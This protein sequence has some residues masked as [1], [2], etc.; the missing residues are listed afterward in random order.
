MPDGAEHLRRLGVALPP[1]RPFRGIRYFDGA[2]RIDGRFPGAPGLGL[3]R[4]RLHAALVEAAE[5]ADV[6][7]RWGVRAEGLQNAGTA[8]PTVLTSHGPMAARL[9][10]GADGLHSK[11]RTWAGLAKPFR[12]RRR[13]GVRRHYGLAPWSDRVEVY[14]SD[15]AE[16]YVTPVGDDEIGV[17]ILWSGRKAGFDALL[18]GFPDLEDKLRGAAHRSRDRGAGPLRQRVRS[19][20]ANRVA[21]VGDAAGYVDAITGEGLSVALHQ[22]AALLDA[23]TEDALP[24]YPRRARRV[25]FLPEAL[26][27]LLLAI[28]AR[29]ALRRRVMRALARDPAL[30]E[31]FLA[32]HVRHCSPGSLLPDLPRMLWRLAAA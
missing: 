26:T 12:G 18:A 4:T 22:S 2:L 10:V 7:C 30:F 20:L 23:F 14:W 1:H 13:F 27:H 25:A 8:R 6:D 21:L 17:A 15:D 3:R 24:T 32:V 11:T 31:G 16:A 28:E 29:P 19:P 9:V 5:S